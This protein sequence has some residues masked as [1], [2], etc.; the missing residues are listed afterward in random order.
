[1]FSLAYSSVFPYLVEDQDHLLLNIE[2]ETVCNL[3]EAAFFV[4]GNAHP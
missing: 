1:M 4:P 3:R 2:F